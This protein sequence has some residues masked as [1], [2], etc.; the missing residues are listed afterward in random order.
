[1]PALPK[2]L[3][4]ATLT[5]TGWYLLAQAA[6]VCVQIVATYPASLAAR[7]EAV[8]A[9]TI[10]DRQAV[11]NDHKAAVEA[12]E[13][14]AK[15]D[16]QGLIAEAETELAR[17]RDR[18]PLRLPAGD[19]TRVVNEEKERNLVSRLEKLK[20]KLDLVEGGGDLTQSMILS[21]PDVPALTLSSIVYR[22]R[23]LRVATHRLQNALRSQD[24]GRFVIGASEALLDTMRIVPTLGF[25][26]L[27]LS[28][29]GTLA[30][31]LI[32]LGR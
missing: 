15:S 11:Y 18:G 3:L 1:M 20:V 27:A 22:Q 17:I 32:S 26:V 4:V 28:H 13:S 2:H 6:I 10:K 14:A 25:L 30:G 29:W 8:G 12:A 7:V 23:D 5:L 31:L 9:S 16:L 24:R 19:A 21:D